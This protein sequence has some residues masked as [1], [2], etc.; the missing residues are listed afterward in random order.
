MERYN[1]V[2]SSP[3]VDRSGQMPLGN[4]D[5]AAGVYAIE[6]GD[7]YMLLAKNDALTYNG[8]IFKTGRV[9]VSLSPNPF[10]KGKPFKQTLDLATGSILIEADGTTIRVWADAGKPV[11]HVQ[12]DSPRDISVSAT[13]DLWKRIDG[14]QWN[15]TKTPIDPP[16]QDVRLER[17]GKIHWAYAGNAFEAC[18]G[19]VHRYRNASPNCRFPLYGSEG[20]DSC[21]DFDHFGSGSTALQRMLVQEAG[22]PSSPDGSVAASKILLLPAWP[23]KWDADFKLH[24]ARQTTISGKVVDGKLLSWKIEPASRKKDV[25]VYE[26]QA[27]PERPP[28]PHGHHPVRLG[29]DSGGSSRYRGQIGRATMFRGM[30]EA[31]MIKKLAAG[32]RGEKLTGENVVNCLLN[33]K[34]GDT[35]PTKHDDFGGAVSFEAWIQPAKGDA[36]R[37]FDKLTAVIER[38]QARVVEARQ[39]MATEVLAE[40]DLMCKEVSDLLDADQT[41]KWEAFTDK[42]RQRHLPHAA[43][44]SVSDHGDR[45]SEQ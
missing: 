11:Y 8:D 10:A 24:V 2:W 34:V 6:D 37:I 22:A 14:C 27:I 1:V 15:T 3:S 33:P 17:D 28:V 29:V 32:D 38:R 4:G 41:R 26:P 19:L 43:S 30:L 16:T 44:A 5:I 23:A 42:V 18:E 21:P 7:L 39:G 12:I 13:S 25:V 40:F 20:P 36:G 9:K 35:L 31:D 45:R